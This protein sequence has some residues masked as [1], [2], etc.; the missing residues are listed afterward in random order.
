[1]PQPAWLTRQQHAKR[2]SEK[3]DAGRIG[4]VFA[5]ALARRRKLFDELRAAVDAGDVI[6]ERRVQAEIEALAL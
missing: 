5:D 3:R 1:M 2:H 6:R 4:S